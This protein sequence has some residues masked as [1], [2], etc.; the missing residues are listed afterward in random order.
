MR[1]PSPEVPGSM[2]RWCVDLTKGKD[3]TYA[4][5]EFGTYHP[6]RVLAGL[7]REDQTHFFA[8]PGEHASNSSKQ[9]L[10]ELV[11]H[12][13]CDKRALGGAIRWCG[14]I[15]V[16]AWVPRAAPSTCL[17]CPNVACMLRSNW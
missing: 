4:A 10:R 7:C 5:V 6:L 12:R 17:H 11:E 16:R 2:G 3:D 13:A 1:A 8:D 9:S 14:C 15:V